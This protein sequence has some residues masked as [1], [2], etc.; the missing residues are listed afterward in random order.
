MILKW[1]I[2]WNEG[3]TYVR[4]LY[5]SASALELEVVDA[6][7][8]TPPEKKASVPRY[9]ARKARSLQTQQRVLPL[10]RRHI[11]ISATWAISTQKAWELF[12]WKK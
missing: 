6:W 9:Q 8:R 10:G 4:I 2:I 3:S 1:P 7:N 5:S 12:F 11:C